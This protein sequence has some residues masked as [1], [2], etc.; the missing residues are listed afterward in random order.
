MLSNIHTHTTFCDG[1]ENPEKYVIAAIEKG[2][3][4]LGFSAHAPVPFSCNW[5]IPSARLTE[6]I[7]TIDLLKEK[8][9][10]KIQIYTGI[11][12]DFFPDIWDYT[13]ELI[14][15]HSFDFHIGSVHFIDFYPDGS[16]WTIDGPNE[17]FRKGF[18]KIFSNDSAT[19]TRKFFEYTRKMIR[20][21]QPP[22][23]GHI[24][25]LKMQSRP[26]SFFPEDTPVFQKE[27]YAT[28]EEVRGTNCIVE[29]N[30][31]GVYKKKSK[32][33]YPGLEALKQMADMR[34]KV[35][36]NSDAHLPQELTEEFSAAKE[37]LKVAG[38]KEHYILKDNTY[39]S[40]SL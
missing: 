1:K 35:M 8:Y 6:Y 16:R 38:F 20:V 24:D 3:V 18:G 5:A 10:S 17:E 2:M 29:L 12:V 32:T 11:E 26:D 13:Y 39:M 36:I 4:S 40:I 14:H 19:V 22:V 31:R 25:K 15:S 33:F 28:L 30:T 34:I 7:S 21:M 27:L 37:M 23:I 9:K